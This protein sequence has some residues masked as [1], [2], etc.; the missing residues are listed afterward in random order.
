MK[1]LNNVNFEWTLEKMVSTQHIET[2]RCSRHCGLLL[3]NYGQLH[4][5][6]NTQCLLIHVH[7]MEND[8]QLP[9][10]ISHVLCTFFCIQ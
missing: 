6:C 4:T 7:Y 2:C 9:L 1:Y 3:T 5:V 8:I 10:L